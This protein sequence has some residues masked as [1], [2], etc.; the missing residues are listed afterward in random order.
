MKRDMELVRDI[1]TRVELQ[2][3]PIRAPVEIEGYTQE[4]I[5]YHIILLAEA[6][7]LKATWRKAMD[8]SK[9]I[10]NVSRLTW[11]GHEF[12]DAARNESAWNAAKEVAKEKGV[13]L[14]FK[15]F[16]SLLEKIV[17]TTVMS[18]TLS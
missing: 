14:P 9:I 12:L 3:G 6:G 1:L 15:I 11:D 5:D 2:N 16:H 18:G 8:G 17:E 7:L 4:V 10:V 13:Q